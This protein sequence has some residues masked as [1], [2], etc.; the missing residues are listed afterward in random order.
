MVV[1]VTTFG[2]GTTTQNLKP[3][4]FWNKEEVDP[5]AGFTFTPDGNCTNVHVKFTNTSKGDGLTYEWNFEDVTKST[6]MDP[7]H[8][9]SSAIGNDT[10]IFTVTLKITDKDNDANSVTQTVTVKEIPSF[11]VTSLKGQ[12]LKFF[13][14]GSSFHHVN[15][16]RLSYYPYDKNGYLPIKWS[17]HGGWNFPSSGYQYFGSK[18]DKMASVVANYKKQGAFQQ[19]DIGAQLLYRSVISGISYRGIPGLRD[20][21][22]QDC[23]ILMLGLNLESRIVIGFSYDFMVSNII[24][25]TKGA[26]EVSI[27]YQF[28]MSNP[29][30]KNQRSRILK[31]F[32]FMM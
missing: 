27:R 29:R 14:L 3:Q 23:I 12:T 8:T 16:P 9:F 1:S 20:M 5:V 25:Q 21:P 31:C 18:F 2:V 17:V 30:Y 15:E 32:D 24:F 6:D 22:N 10:K 4:R 7:T 28:F 26:H 19:V 11:N 13:W